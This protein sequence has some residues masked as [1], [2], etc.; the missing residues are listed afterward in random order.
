MKVEE[1]PHEWE[2]SFFDIVWPGKNIITNII[3]MIILID[4]IIVFVVQ[5]IFWGLFCSFAVI[6]TLIII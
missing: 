4:Y 1:I 3:F 2:P 6:I 5:L